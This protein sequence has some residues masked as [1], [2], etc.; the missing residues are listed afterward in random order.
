MR[1]FW[2]KFADPKPYAA[3]LGAGVTAIDEVDARRLIVAAFGQ[4][5]Q[6]ETVGVVGTVDDLDQGHV[7]PNM[8]NILRR[9]IWFPLGYDAV[10]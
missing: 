8:G 1:P 2:I 5:A 6:I 7:V 4:T 3:M 10:A 9:A